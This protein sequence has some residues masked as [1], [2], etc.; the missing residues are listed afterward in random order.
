MEIISAA[1][2]EEAMILEKYTCD[3]M[4]HKFVSGSYTDRQV[5][6]FHF[7]WRNYR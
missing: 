4:N 1:F 3:D 6:I 5:T 7:T 2:N